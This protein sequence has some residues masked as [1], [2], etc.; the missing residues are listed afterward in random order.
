M[1][2]LPWPWSL[3]YFWK[4][5]TLAITH[6][7]QEV[8]LSYFI[9]VFL[10]ARPFKWYHIVISFRPWPWSLT[11]FWTTLTLAITHIPQ[12]VG[13]SYLACVFLMTT[14]FSRYHIFIPPSLKGPLGTSSNAIIPPHLQSA[15]FFGWWYGNQTWNDAHLWVAH[16]TDITCPWDGVVS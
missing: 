13:L 15:I 5:L 10:M 6:L 16:I 9:M 3:T 1:T 14:S 11:Y 7:P 8:E 2:L 4:T 12:E